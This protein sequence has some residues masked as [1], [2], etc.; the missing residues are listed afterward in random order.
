MRPG[1]AATLILARDL[2][3]THRIDAV[4]IDGAQ[5]AYRSRTVVT[6]SVRYGTMAALP[7]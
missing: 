6:D 3:G 5:A 2:H 7:I 4:V 1:L